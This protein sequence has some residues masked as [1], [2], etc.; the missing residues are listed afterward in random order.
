MKVKFIKGSREGEIVDAPDKRAVYWQRMGM[1][2]EVI[3]TKKVATTHKEPT[4]KP[5]KKKK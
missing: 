4:K 5:Q 1:V 3:E 2:E